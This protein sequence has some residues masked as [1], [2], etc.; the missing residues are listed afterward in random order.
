MQQPNTCCQHD[1]RLRVTFRSSVFACLV[2]VKCELFSRLTLMQMVRCEQSAHSKRTNSATYKR[3]YR[4]KH[5]CL[6]ASL[7]SR[8]SAL[9]ATVGVV[10]ARRTSILLRAKVLRI[11]VAGLHEEARCRAPG[12]KEK[13][14]TVQ[15]LHVTALMANSRADRHMG[16]S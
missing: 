12:S 10:V 16:S 7:F 11:G 14:L 13:D 9:S 6:S 2:A 4:G 1:G 3:S 15:P 8:Y 5:T